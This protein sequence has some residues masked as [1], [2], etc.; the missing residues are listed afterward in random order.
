VVGP[1]RGEIWLV[2][3]SPVRGPEQART[4]PGLVVSVDDLNHGPAGLAVVPIT[5]K[6]KGIPFHVAVP[7]QEGGV[8][9]R[10]YIKSEDVRSISKE[11]LANRIARSRWTFWPKLRTGCGSS[12]LVPELV[13][14]TREWPCVSQ[15]SEPAHQLLP[16]DARG[17]S[18]ACAFRNPYLQTFDNWNG[19]MISQL[20]E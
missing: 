9:E 5:T 20:E 11:R 17:H 16:R 8:G 15:G 6:A 10:S 14:T 7:A 19:V 18:D 1:S 3:L 4:R 13:L 12:R 2:D